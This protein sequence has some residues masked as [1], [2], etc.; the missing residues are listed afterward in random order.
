MISRMNP[1]D[2]AAKAAP[3]LLQLLA[4][5]LAIAM[6]ILP[7]DIVGAALRYLDVEVGSADLRQPSL[8]CCR[9]EG[10]H[11]FAVRR[12]WG[13]SPTRPWTSNL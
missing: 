12:F 5:L 6:L 13:S 3:R 11:S 7:L 9:H 1:H 8:R 4:I 2:K 10:I